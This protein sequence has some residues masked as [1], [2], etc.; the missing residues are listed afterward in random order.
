MQDLPLKNNS[1]L[2][3]YSDEEIPERHSAGQRNIIVIRLPVVSVYHHG[4][5][6]LICNSKSM[7]TRAL[8]GIH[9]VILHN[10]EGAARGFT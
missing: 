10:P 7:P 2:I 1:T 9:E 4:L 5:Y 3:L 6:T 8:S